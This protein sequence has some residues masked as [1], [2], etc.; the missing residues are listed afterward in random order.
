MNRCEIL[1]SYRRIF[2]VVEV[3]VVNERFS[4][5]DKPFAL[6]SSY[7]LLAPSHQR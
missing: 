6:L 1:F 4:A 7:R 3:E 2:S 5:C